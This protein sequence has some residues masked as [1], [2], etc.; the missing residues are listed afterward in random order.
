MNIHFGEDYTVFEEIRCNRCIFNK[1]IVISEKSVHM[2][3]YR[4]KKYMIE[5]SIDEI[6]AMV[7]TV[8]ND[9]D[10]YFNK[11]FLDFDLEI[12]EHKKYFE[13]CK[14]DV[15]PDYTIFSDTH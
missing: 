6:P 10:Y 1:M 3:N 5:C 15:F 2:E 12:E 8:L 11:L 4:L 7:E 9:Y 14:R 13:K